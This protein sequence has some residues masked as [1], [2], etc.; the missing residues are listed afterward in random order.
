MEQQQK[1]KKE[2]Q[3]NNKKRYAKIK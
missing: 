3:A 1:T 2:N